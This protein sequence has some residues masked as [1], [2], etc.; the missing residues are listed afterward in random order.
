MG[1]LRAARDGER[2]T[3]G[4]IGELSTI[5]VPAVFG[6]IGWAVLRRRNASPILAGCSA[7][8]LALTV[9]TIMFVVIYFV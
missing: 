2:A 4:T 3:M 1:C 9:M 7:L 8:T 5:V 6:L